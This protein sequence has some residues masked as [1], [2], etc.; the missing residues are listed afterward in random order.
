MQ[1][2]TFQGII[3][4]PQGAQVGMVEADM[5]VIL[6]GQVEHGAGDVMVDVPAED[7]VVVPRH[8]VCE[9]ALDVGHEFGGRAAEI[10]GD[11]VGLLDAALGAHLAEAAGEALAEHVTL[12]FGATTPASGVCVLAT[13]LRLAVLLASGTVG[14]LEMPRDRERGPATTGAVGVRDVGTWR[15]ALLGALLPLAAAAH[16][17]VAAKLL[18]V[19]TRR[20][21]D[22]ALGACHIVIVQ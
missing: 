11:G 6:A 2:V 17:S 16:A 3:W 4:S 1:P 18:V 8:A 22:G 13:A 20:E 9:L 5:A 10:L 12:V 19:L 21:F 7:A 14:L 15:L